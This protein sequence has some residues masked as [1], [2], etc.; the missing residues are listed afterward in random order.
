MADGAQDCGSPIAYLV[1]QPGTAV[2]TSGRE[3]IG[4]V[5]QVLFVQEEDVFDG[6]VVQTGDGAR[7]VDASD[8]DSIF[9]R[10][11]ITSLSLE[12]AKALSPP[13]TAPPVSASSFR[14]LVREGA[15]VEALAPPEERGGAA[16]V[17]DE[18]DDRAQLERSGHRGEPFVRQ[19]EDRLLRP[20]A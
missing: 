15:L 8:V 17:G 18:R 3:R 7:F 1:L 9:E 6:I 10:C 20:S 14:P 2:Y 4:T 11:V 5:E 19:A 12:Q 13:E 16:H